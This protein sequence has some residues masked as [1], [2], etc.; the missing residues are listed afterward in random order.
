M[1]DRG[2]SAV[3]QLLYAGCTHMR[4]AARSYFG[5]PV[6]RSSKPQ[7]QFVAR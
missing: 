2:R 3:A 4:K 1:H 7:P 6:L 5:K